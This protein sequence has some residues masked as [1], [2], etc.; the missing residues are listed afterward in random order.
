[1]ISDMKK[2]MRLYDEETFGPV[3]PLTPFSG[4]EEDAIRLANEDSLYGLSGAVYS[5]NKHLAERVASQIHAGQ[6]GI[7]C[8]AL[9]HMD[10]ACPWVGHKESGFVYH[11]GRQGFEQLSLPKTIVRMGGK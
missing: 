4:S 11:S 7:N 6:V 10:V 2:G 3:V 9:D 5:K 1:M 8:H